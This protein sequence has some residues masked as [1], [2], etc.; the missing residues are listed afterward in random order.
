MSGGDSGVSEAD[1]LSSEAALLEDW[2][3]VG[4]IPAHGE[5]TYNMIVPTLADS[6]IT[7]G[8]HWS[9][10]F[11][12]AATNDPFTFFDSPPDSGYSLDNLAPGPPMSVALSS[13][14]V[15]MWDEASEPDFD[16]FSIYGSSASS[17]DGTA[18]LLGYTTEESYD[19]ATEPHN[20]YHVTA[21]DFAGNEGE[22]RSV[23][24]TVVGVPDVPSPLVLSL[25]VDPN[26]FNPVTTIK[27]SL[28]KTGPV[29]LAVYD[30]RGRLIETIIEDEIQ[31]PNE[32]ELRWRTEAATGVY[33]VR[34][35]A[36]GETRITKV[37]LLK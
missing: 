22:A 33:F 3:F 26:P 30:V 13:F 11:I 4:A 34:L 28:L 5:D 17:L 6:T 27:Y 9:V 8:Q 7:S 32:Y 23:S 1:I 37:I 14:G 24:N 21:T 25:Q 20:Y 18:S 12:R 2:E 10:F 16:F 31:E 36:A 35:L 29:T 19:V 15:L